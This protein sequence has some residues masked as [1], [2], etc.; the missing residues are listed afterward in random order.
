[1]FPENPNESKYHTVILNI[2]EN[3]KQIKSALIKTKDAIS[4]HFEI[5]DLEG[6]PI[7]KENLFKWALHKHPSVDLIDN[8]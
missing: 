8:R 6:N 7:V 4:I 1:M 5:I 3:K 2:N